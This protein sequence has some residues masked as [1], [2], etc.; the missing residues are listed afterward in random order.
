MGG[1]TNRGADDGRR[2]SKTQRLISE[3][4]TREKE[5]TEGKAEKEQTELIEV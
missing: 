3:R 2:F 4:E 5:R 1:K